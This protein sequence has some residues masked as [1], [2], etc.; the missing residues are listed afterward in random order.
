MSVVILPIELCML[1]ADSADTHVVAHMALTCKQWYHR[2]QSELRTYTAHYR[3]MQNIGS[4]HY[5]IQDEHSVR[6]TDRAIVKYHV[7]QT[8]DLEFLYSLAETRHAEMK[9]VKDV[10]I[11]SILLPQR[12]TFILHCE[13]YLPFVELHSELIDMI[14]EFAD[15]RT[16]G[17]MALT[18][19]QYYY[20]NLQ[21]LR[22][23]AAYH[24][25]MQ[26]IR[27]QYYV[28]TPYS[29]IRY[30][31][32]NQT[33]YSL[34]W[35]VLHVVFETVMRAGS[36]SPRI[37]DSLRKTG[38]KIFLDNHDPLAVNMPLVQTYDVIRDADGYTVNFLVNLYPNWSR[39]SPT[40]HWELCMLIA[41]FSDAYTRA[42]MALTCKQWYHKLQPELR[43]Y[44]GHR[45]TLRSIRAL[46]Y[47]T[48]KDLTKLYLGTKF[49][50][51]E[52]ERKPTEI[53][54][55]YSETDTESSGKCIC[56]ER[57]SYKIRPTRPCL[58]MDEHEPCVPMELYALVAEVS[59][60]HTR[61]RMAVTCAFLYYS[62]KDFLK[63]YSAHNR[64]MRLIK[65][66]YFFSESLRC[67]VRYCNEPKNESVRY[68]VIPRSSN[69]LKFECI[70]LECC[71][72]KPDADVKTSIREYR[73]IK[74][75]FMVDVVRNDDI[76][77]LHSQNDFR[78]WGKKRY[79]FSS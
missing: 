45:Q 28:T 53:L 22:E 61:A 51:Y 56:S 64:T 14:A 19:Q 79:W 55:V 37:H 40:L 52:L 9:H 5:F 57:E 42:C 74:V 10:T 78:E 48:S 46:C 18:S 73:S 35:S 31:G 60:P 33:T 4:Q 26:H 8:E 41:E 58:T 44:T 11:H 50:E 63:I 36:K 49:T 6:Q 20:R 13:E 15:V 66:D 67:S 7:Y 59:D 75:G 12:N 17:R 24:R 34:H 32:K 71:R 27:S 1:I 69:L 54:F 39:R 3:S 23:R 38:E 65:S 25:V 72:R 43:A 47:W 76:W 16:R 62:L 68:A 30:Y 70:D 21:F 2:L 29:S 77:R